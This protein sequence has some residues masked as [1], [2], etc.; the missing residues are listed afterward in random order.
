MTKTLEDSNLTKRRMREYLN[1][2]R[3]SYAQAEEQCGFKR[4]FLSAGGIVGSDKL[5]MFIEAY[6]DT[7]LYYLVSGR[8]DR[9]R[10]KLIK[11]LQRIAG[12]VRD[13][14]PEEQ[15]DDDAQA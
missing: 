8:H 15:T 2:R 7:D 1:K 10:L 14:P 12:M 3:I 11:I 13:F 4:G 6:P 9:H 5:A